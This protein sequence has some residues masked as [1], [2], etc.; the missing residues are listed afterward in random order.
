MGRARLSDKVSCL[1]LDARELDGGDLPPELG[2]SFGVVLV[3]APCSG[4]GTM[5]RHP[6]APA[7]LTEADVS[8]LARL[9]RQIEA[10][11]SARVA[12]GGALVYSTCSVMREEDED[13]VAAFLAS[14]AGRDFEV[15]PVGAAPAC[16]AS[17]ALAEVVRTN[18]TP[19]GFMLTCP[20]A[21]SG[22]GHFC[23][24]LV[25]RA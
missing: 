24:R 5:R 3:D 14:D 9:Q 15:E 18:Q 25:R 21:G 17:P 7:R 2:R 23:A 10:A 1:Q 13:V 6:E 4:T 22:D 19:D 16:V 11:A 8:D 12:L 20:A